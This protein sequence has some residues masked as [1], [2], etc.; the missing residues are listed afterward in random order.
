ML[1]RKIAPTFAKEFSF[2][3]PA[4]QIIELGN[5]IPITWL[6]GLQQEVAKIEIIFQ[7][8]KWYESKPGVSYF[9]ANML[10]KGTRELTST[11]IAERLDQQGAQVEI[12]AGSDYTSVGLYSLVKNLDQTLPILLQIIQQPSFDEDELTLLSDIFLE[13][14]KVSN[15]KTGVVAS[16]TLQRNIFGKNH[17]YGRSVEPADVGQVTASDLHS[18]FKKTFVPYQVFITGN[19]RP[20]QIDA[21]SQ[22]ISSY[23]QIQFSN[24]AIPN[25][26]GKPFGENV[27]KENSVQSSVRLGRI[28]LSKSHPDYG[29]LLL[30]NHILGGYFGSRLMKNIREEKGLTYGISS[31]IHSH[32]NAGFM[33]IAT[34]VNKEKLEPTLVEIKKE[35]RFLL[36]IPIP[37]AELEISKNHFLGNLQLEISNPFSA[38][39]KIKQLKLSN[40]PS[41]YYSD[42]FYKVT[43]ITDGQLQAIAN[44]WLVPESFYQVTVG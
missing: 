2:V 34:D 6:N 1:D 12:S 9:T 42:L 29:G 41:N 13:N 38:M 30:L 24:S 27:T 11:K 5:G 15:E 31:S 16:K 23:A 36:D 17:P 33:A 43:T 4:P 14:L 3:L 19:L 7:A 26:N 35:I 18:F 44:E 10:E 28:T 37:A 40:L 22:F 8:G 25:E 21:V 39:D 32:F 20:S